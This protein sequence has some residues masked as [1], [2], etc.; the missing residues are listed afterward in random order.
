MPQDPIDL[1]QLPDGSIFYLRRDATCRCSCSTDSDVAW[2]R[3]GDWCIRDAE[4]G[5]IMHP[6]CFAMGVLESRLDEALDP[7]HDEAFLAPFKESKFERGTLEP[8]EVD[9]AAQDQSCASCEVAISSFNELG[10][11]GF[12]ALPDESGLNKYSHTSCIQEYDD[13][14]DKSQL[15]STDTAAIDIRRLDPIF[16]PFDAEVFTPSEGRL[17]AQ[18]IDSIYDWCHENTQGCAT[19]TCRVIAEEKDNAPSGSRRFSLHTKS[20][21]LI[22]ISTGE[23]PPGYKSKGYYIDFPTLG[24]PENAFLSGDT[25]SG[26]L[27]TAP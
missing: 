12:C 18:W 21:D 15:A 25:A 22:D 17:S 19:N 8:N 1:T 13:T 24:R 3:E 7:K 23:S 6:T 20:E 9:V 10:Q 16:K 5:T 2:I 4:N 14:R 26:D 11:P 27:M